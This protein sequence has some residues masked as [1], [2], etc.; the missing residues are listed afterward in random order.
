M[1]KAN[2][3][4]RRLALI[5]GDMLFPD[6][7]ALHPD[8]E[9]LFFMAEDEGL[10]T[11]FRYHQQKLVLFLS[12]MRHHADR[13]RQEHPLE[14]LALDPAKADP[15]YEEKLSALREKHPDLE[16]LVTY[17]IEDA[18]FRKRLQQ[19]CQSQ[20]LRLTV[21]D[22]PKFLF[23]ISDFDA[24]LAEAKK[25]F[26]NQYYIRQRKAR[27]ILLDD[28]GGPL[29]GHWSFDQDNRKK[30][31]AGH[32]SPAW[33]QKRPNAHDEAVISLAEKRF[34][35]H[36][37]R[38]RQFNWA[39]TRSEAQEALQGFLSERFALFGPYED[40]FEAEEVF[41]Y[42]SALSP[43][44]NLGLLTPAEVLEEALQF[45]TAQDVHYP[46]VEGFVRQILGWREFLRGMYR[47]YRWEENYFGHEGKLS[48]HWYRGD[49]GIPPLD[50]SIRKALH[51]GYTHHIER[52]MVIGNLML[53]SGIHP[54]EVYRW[55]MEL[56]VDSADWVMAPNVIGMSQFADGGRFATKP[57]LSGS[58]Y[59]RK[60]SHY[61]KGDWCTVVDGL[62]WRFIALHEE[63]F[64]QNRRMAMM[65]ATL[66][67]M[68]P[69]KK[70]RIFDA[71]EKWIAKVVQ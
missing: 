30:L 15:S 55:F 28:Q 44:L 54:Q 36:P 66:R 48:E 35:S 38:A 21:V 62:Y 39:T 57:Y 53:M 11:H 47:S 40:A 43:Y 19:W 18:F 58:N 69:D 16:E 6:H 63:T 20:G 29:H 25:P 14:Y 17:E 5:L 42:H 27:G 3:S 34:S 12:A 23:P 22:S 9:T 33:P 26:L 61:P 4:Y 1:P 41:I 13:I 71:A 46:S 8:E 37:G 65:V 50:D 7:R 68:N 70:E 49:T 67:K 10:C 32:Q 60:M 31:P 56:Y 51:H 2:R 24:Y 64:A 45:A 52:L 59:L